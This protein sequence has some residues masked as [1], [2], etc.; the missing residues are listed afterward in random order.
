MKQNLVVLLAD[1][2]NLFELHPAKC[3]IYP[4]MDPQQ[5][6]KKY[7]IRMAFK[8]NK[9]LILF[10]IKQKFKFKTQFGD[11]NTNLFCK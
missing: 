6:N 8:T 4:G 9:L 10:L 7:S 2:F 3:V 5:G 11:G 1:L